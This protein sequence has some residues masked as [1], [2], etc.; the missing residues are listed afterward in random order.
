MTYKN[1]T[2]HSV[3]DFIEVIKVMHQKSITLEELIRYAELGEFDDA[4]L[5]H[6]GRIDY[7]ISDIQAH[8]QQLL[9]G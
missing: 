8:A 9:H 3:E 6:K 2:Y 4:E 1:L 5:D 7:L